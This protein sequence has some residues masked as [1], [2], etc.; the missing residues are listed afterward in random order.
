MKLILLTHRRELERPTNT[1]QLIQQCLPDT[2]KVVWQRKHPDPCLLKLIEQKQVA[3]LYRSE[4]ALTASLKQDF[5]YFILIDA[6]WQEARK[7][8][9][10]S[11]YLH[12]LPHLTLVP[13]NASRYHLRRNQP[14]GGLCTV[15]CALE[16]MTTFRHPIRLD[17]QQTY[18]DFLDQV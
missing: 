16:L 18:D 5:E 2:L 1:G 6:T 3:L 12:G 11:P 8:Y 10:H 13:A 7:I 9:N 4:R 17:L 15:E 14:E